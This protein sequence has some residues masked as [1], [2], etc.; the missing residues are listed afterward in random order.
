MAK[1][2]FASTVANMADRNT[3][4]GLLFF[5]KSLIMQTLSETWRIYRRHLLHND[6]PCSIWWCC[7]TA[8]WFVMGKMVIDII[9]EIVIFLQ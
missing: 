4:E 8:V 7:V 3:G 2:I 5:L 9:A 6:T 1:T